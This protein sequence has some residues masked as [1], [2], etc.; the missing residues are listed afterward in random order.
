MRKSSFLLTMFLCV[1][2]LH[3]QAFSTPTP[4]TLIEVSLDQLHPTQAVIGFD[5]IYYKLARF[6]DQR[7]TLFDEYCETNGQ[8]E[9]VRVT[10]ASDLLDPATFDCQSPVGT[11]SKD[12]KT[13]VI[14]PGGKLYLTDGHHTF[15]TLWDQPGAGPHLRMWVKVTDDF[16]DSADS[17]TFWARMQHAHKTWLKDG[18][19]QTINP[20]QLPEHLGLK[21]MQNDLF[22]GLVY[23][24][25]GAAYGKPSLAD[26][27]PEFLEFY[28]GDWLRAR[29]DITPFD[30]VDRIGYRK[31]LEAAS[32]LMV[33][34]P[35]AALVGDSGFNARQLGGYSSVDSKTLR[36]TVH[37]KLRYVF[38]YKA[39]H[40]LINSQ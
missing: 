22:R 2:T 26:I 6:A 7:S 39:A 9:S 16:S 32:D 34:L 15:T 28:W 30:L 31:A 29:L 21:N 36:K 3:A 5:Q 37:D 38:D 11:R 27:A 20:A 35:A 13:V 8:S 14:G 1:F 18:S 33:A 10:N 40:H 19:G 4:G 23:F 24:T 25:R 17:G 12:M